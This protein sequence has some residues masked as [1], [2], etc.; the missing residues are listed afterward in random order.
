MCNPLVIAAVAAVAGSALG[1]AGTLQQGE[2]AKKV[3]EANA[4][5]M[6][7]AA[8]SAGDVGAQKASD[9]I[10]KAKEL[11]GSQA[12]AAGAGGID[13]FTGTPLKV[14]GE[15][16]EFGELD[17]LRIVNN[18]SRQ[19]WGLESE[20]DIAAYEGTQEQQASYL[21]AGSQLL[22]GASKAYFGA[23]GGGG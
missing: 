2:T 16:T 18:A 15:T 11:A 7:I 9:R 4:F 21:S 1:A 20:A 8:K 23:K 3:G 12:A 17:A 6:R 14:Q 5:N 13:P 10:Q 19:A 22:G